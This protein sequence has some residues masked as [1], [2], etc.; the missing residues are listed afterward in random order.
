MLHSSANISSLLSV[1]KAHLNSSWAISSSTPISSAFSIRSSCKKCFSRLAKN[2]SLSLPLSLASLYFLNASTFFCKSSSRVPLTRSGKVSALLNWSVYHIWSLRNCL[3]DSAIS[4][5]YVAS[6]NNPAE[7][8]IFALSAKNTSLAFPSIATKSPSLNVI[9]SKLIIAGIPAVR[10]KTASWNESLPKVVIKPTLGKDD[11][12]IKISLRV[13]CV[14]TKITGPLL[15]YSFAFSIL[16][17]IVP[18]IA[19]G[20]EVTPLPTTSLSTP[21]F[22]LKT[23]RSAILLCKSSSLGIATSSEI[24]PSLTASFIYCDSPGG[25]NLTSR[26]CKKYKTPSSMTNSTSCG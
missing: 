1:A 17:A 7:T 25:A 11:I 22:I 20:I 19:P 4:T 16:N 10:V 23:S 21:S 8:K 6:K 9:F 14:A 12:C 24:T 18:A 13:S 2:A 26:V 3:L 5:P 15:A